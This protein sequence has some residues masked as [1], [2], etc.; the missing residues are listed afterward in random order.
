MIDSAKV[1]FFSGNEKKTRFSFAFLSFFRKFAIKMAK[2]LYLG[3]KKESILFVL[4][5]FFRNFAA[6]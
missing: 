2:L 6:K 4:L 5:S 3:I 1:R